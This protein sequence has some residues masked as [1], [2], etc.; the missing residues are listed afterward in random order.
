[1]VL[2]LDG[3]D[4]L[5]DKDRAH[6]MFWLPSMCPKNVHII[7]ST[8]T[9]EYD[10][11]NKLV[12]KIG[13]SEQDLPFLNISELDIETLKMLLK[14][15]GEEKRRTLLP[16]QLE[17]L[18]KVCERN[19]NALYVTRM[20]REALA[21]TS[22]TIVTD[23]VLPAIIDESVW[24]DLQRIEIKHG[25]SLVQHTL[26]YLA[27]SPRGLTETELKDALSTDDVVM[28]E[29]LYKSEQLSKGT[30]SMP[31]TF[32]IALLHDLQNFVS[33]CHMDGKTVICWKHTALKKMVSK[34]YFDVDDPLSTECRKEATFF[35]KTLAKVLLQE[36]GIKKTF[37]HPQTKEMHEDAD[38]GVRPQPLKPSNR[39]KLTLCVK[40]LI[41]AMLTEN[42]TD[43]LKKNCL[44]S[45]YWLLTSMQGLS[46]ESILNDVT[47][48]KSRDPEICLMQDFLR[49]ASNGLRTDPF[50]LAAH[51][52]G[53]ISTVNPQRF[54]M[55]V[56][57]LREAMHWLEI[58]TAP[59]LVPAFPCLASA[60]D[61]C[62]SRIWGLTD[63]LQV[64]R[65]GQLGV[66]K[67]KEGFIE[68]W[69]LDK[70]E[71]VFN[72][73]VQ[74]DRVTPNVFT[75]EVQ[76]LTL[77]GTIL[78]VWDIESGK[79]L[80]SLD[81]ENHIGTNTTAFNITA[82]TQDFK[83]VSVLSS[84]E[85]FNQVIRIIDIESDSVIHQ[86]PSFDVKD[87]F[88]GAKS[89]V[90]LKYK[91]Y[92]V[93]VSART[94]TL[95]DD[96]QADIVKLNCFDVS[97]GGYVYRTNCGKQ[98][99]S[100]LLVKNERKAYIS[101]KLGGFDIFDIMTGTFERKIIAPEHDHLVHE[102]KLV[103]KNHIAFLTAT[104]EEKCQKLCSVLW[105]W[106][107]GDSEVKN[108]ISQEYTSEDEAIKQ[109]LLSDSFTFAV[110]SAPS[111]SRIYIWNLVTN[112]CVQSIEAHADNIDSLFQMIDP[113][114]FCSS[115]SGEIVVKLWDIYDLVPHE[116]ADPSPTTEEPN[117]ITIPSI[118]LSRRR[119]SSRRLRR[120]ISEPDILRKQIS[121]LKL[122]TQRSTKS[123]RFA[124]EVPDDIT[125]CAGTE[126]STYSTEI[127][128]GVQTETT[129][130]TENENDECLDPAANRKYDRPNMDIIL[131]YSLNVTSLQYSR[132]GKYI[133]TGSEEL[134]PVMWEA[135]SARIV[136]KMTPHNDEDVG[137]P[138]VKFALN[139]KMIAGLS[140]DDFTKNTYPYIYMFHVS[141]RMLVNLQNHQF[142]I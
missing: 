5:S 31:S 121:K 47:M 11:L 56:G 110:L 34:K 25:T 125:S 72:L 115:S 111:I 1:M 81:L 52:L 98:T 4:L 68:I 74:Y 59:I 84:D 140:T 129:S 75:T 122:E 94:E 82:H 86:L 55:F 48:V 9:N 57:L 77:D 41:S 76:V 130:S 118:S 138:I 85:D 116:P 139:D 50:S 33:R 135:H 112:I 70:N 30:I 95:A 137:T 113:Y 38:R 123:V 29:I 93:F 80:R 13:S 126:V 10:I 40:Y 67:N 131:H 12:L 64:N 79:S 87:E 92:L 141:L 62:K 20:I 133:I 14:R 108:L 114:K 23:D 120:S 89:A 60:M 16:E 66:M 99:F 27:V 28:E 42:D 101:W 61:I 97:S 2:L 17:V 63:I 142:A 46:A 15:E 39:R 96:T 51:L 37:R 90:F 32:L 58:N 109:F 22:Y 44:G 132:D 19:A 49:L 107:L 54:P 117:L 71:V 18:M 124:D 102:A 104:D 136:K 21:W 119:S 134:Y 73:G 78:K 69:D 53:S 43:L 35:L 100:S 88:F 26:C 8:D 3:L 6:T 24:Y 106:D 103:N 127:P 45:F 91:P 7:V 105:L 128:S 36:N 65:S 83:L